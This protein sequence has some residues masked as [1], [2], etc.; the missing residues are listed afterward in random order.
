MEKRKYTQ[1][2]FKPLKE[3]LPAYLEK[4]I[5]RDEILKRLNLTKDGLRNFLIRNNIKVWDIKKKKCNYK[6][7]L[8]D[9]RKF[10]KGKMTITD[11]ANKHNLSVRTVKNKLSELNIETNYKKKLKESKGRYFNIKE[12]RNSNKYARYFYEFNKW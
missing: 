2:K 3:L 5:T 11:L 10:K 6:K 7:F 4:K 12:E 8:S 1:D 9:A